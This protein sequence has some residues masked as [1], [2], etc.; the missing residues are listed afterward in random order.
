[1]KK[2]KIEVMINGKIPAI[3]DGTTQNCGRPGRPGCG[4]EIGF[5]RT[6]AGKILP[7]DMDTYT[8][9]FAT[10]PVRENFRREEK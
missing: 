4:A 7:F 9:H 1:M 2:E 5:G 10:C 6:E 8:A 3:W